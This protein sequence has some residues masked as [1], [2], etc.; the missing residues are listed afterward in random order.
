MTEHR[1]TADL[2]EYLDAIDLC[3]FDGH[4]ESMGVEIRWMR[5]RGT[6]DGAPATVGKF[7]PESR[8]IEIAR[9]LAHVS[10]PRVYVMQVVHHEACHAV[11]GTEH[12][13]AFHA[14][15]RQFLHTYEAQEWERAGTPW[16]PVP[17][18]LR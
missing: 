7:W 5:A 4:L 17:K 6:R 16:P 3:Y 10:V 13:P 15:C 18:G 1:T 8:L 2:R 9:V 12:S 11:Y 14:A